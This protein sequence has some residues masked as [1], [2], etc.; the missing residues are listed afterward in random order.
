MSAETK[1]EIQLEIADVLFIDVVGFSK[2]RS[3]IRARYLSN[4]SGKG[5]L[6]L[7]S[8]RPWSPRDFA[9]IFADGCIL[10]FQKNGAQ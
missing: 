5:L 2:F 10:R 3:T 9:S 1:K 8:L 4:L 6:R 7:S